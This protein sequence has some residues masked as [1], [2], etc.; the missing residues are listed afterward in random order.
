MRIEWLKE[1]WGRGDCGGIFWGG[2]GVVAGKILPGMS[3]PQRLAVPAIGAGRN[4]L[5]CAPTGT[6][7]TLCAFI[8]ILSDLMRRRGEGTLWIGWI[9]CM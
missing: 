2:G 4:V 3:L 1:M 5:V 6:G 7:K 8:S 9:R